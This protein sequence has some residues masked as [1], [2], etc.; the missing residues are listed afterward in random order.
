MKVV[1]ISDLHGNLVD[2]PKCDLLLIAGDICPATDHSNEFQKEWLWSEFHPWLTW[3]KAEKIV[4]I[5][6]NHDWIFENDPNIG[7]SLSPYYLCEDSCVVFGLKIYGH[8]W[9]P[10][11]CD[12]AFN[13][14]H[15]QRIAVNSKIPDDTD[16]IIA[17]GPPRGVLDTV[18]GVTELRHGKEVKE[19]L[20]CTALMQAVERVKPKLC[21]FGHI[22]SGRGVVKK[23]GT[24]FVNASILD[25]QYETGYKIIELEL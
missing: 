8:P 17:H 7:K 1:T 6:G 13:A 10:R 19:H 9:T 21:V 11:F 4:W 23:N 20:G 2:T 24:T 12:W 25:E 5:A 18:E 15:E 14:N 22:H 3:Q 16:I